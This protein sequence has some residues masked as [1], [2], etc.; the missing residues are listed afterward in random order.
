MNSANLTQKFISYVGML[1]GFGDDVITVLSLRALDH[2]DDR[3]VLSPAEQLQED[4]EYAQQEAMAWEIEHET[5][6]ERSK[7]LPAD[8]IGAILKR[9]KAPRQAYIKDFL[10]AGAVTF[11]AAEP[12]SGKTTFSLHALGALTRGKE[13]LGESL[14]PTI[15]LYATEQTE[16]SYT[17]QA[18]KVSDLIENQNFRVILYED[19]TVIEDKPVRQDDGQTKFVPTDVFPTSWEK[20]IALWTFAIKRNNAKVFV[21]DTLTAFSNFRSG[22]AFDPG[23]VQARLQDLK[24]LISKFPDLAILILHHLRKEKNDAN[25]YETVK[26]FNDIANSYAL[27]AGSDQNILFY[28]PSS[29]EEDKMVRTVRIEGRFVEQETTFQIVLTP[30]GFEKRQ[31]PVEEPAEDEQARLLGLCLKNPTLNNQ[32]IRDI[33]ETYGFKKNQVERFRQTWARGTQPTPFLSECLSGPGQNP[34]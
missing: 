29:N 13:F 27:R 10:Y 19:N 14:I 7:N 25:R 1:L 22:E 28:C 12:K 18:E 31:Q 32:P 30:D 8:T 6:K 5:I 33:M 9:P 4:L 17:T 11:L 2:L 26:S 3:H 24:I 21:I 15:V 16:I 23:V 20:Q 34:K